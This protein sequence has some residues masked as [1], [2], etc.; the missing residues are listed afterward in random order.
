MQRLLQDDT[1][2]V[3]AFGENSGSLD[4]KQAT[5]QLEIETEQFMNNLADS[6][7]EQDSED[8]SL[9]GGPLSSARQGRVG[10]VRPG[11]S[12]GFS[13]AQKERLASVLLEEELKACLAAVGD[14]KKRHRSLG[15]AQ[16]GRGGRQEG[17][18]E[19]L[20]ARKSDK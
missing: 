20:S 12:S 14:I 16:R 17:E 15:P 13:D 7:D 6:I 4:Q 18:E 19:K 10:A 3:A 11:A 1:K 2:P 8:E 9:E 5:M